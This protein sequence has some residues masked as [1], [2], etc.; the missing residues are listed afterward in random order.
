M[1]GAQEGWRLLRSANAVSV[2]AEALLC[3][4]P[5]PLGVV[6]FQSELLHCQNPSKSNPRSVPSEVTRSLPVLRLVRIRPRLF[7]IEVISRTLL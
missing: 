6:V 2:Y 3:V 7:D 1:I 4:L 5:Q